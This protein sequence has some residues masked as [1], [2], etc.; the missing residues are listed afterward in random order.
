MYEKVKLPLYG[1]LLIVLVVIGIS[2]TP[3]NGGRFIDSHAIMD[4]VFKSIDNTK[5]L[6]YTMVY[7]ERLNETKIHTDSNQVKFQKTPRKLY[8][9]LSDGTEV[10]WIDGENKN[11]AL[12]HPNSFPYVTLSLDPD[13]SIMRKDQHHSITSTGYDYFEDLLK[14][15]ADNSKADFDSHFLYLGEVTFNGAK[16]YSMRVLAPSFKYVPYVVQKGETVITIAKKLC[17]SEYKI[18]EYNHLSSYTSVVAGQE[19]VVP[20]SYAKE[21]TLYIDKTTMLPLFVKVED[22]KGLF[23]QYIFKNVN[24][25]AAIL[26]EEFSRKAKEYHF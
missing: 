23:E 19:L 15:V 3:F 10:L 12:V 11:E 24:V 2:A 26:D 7:S 1:S 14:Q 25:N 13:G 16:C 6:K 18:R 5:T 9:K 4:D 22:D 20:D 8:V 21:M 17:L